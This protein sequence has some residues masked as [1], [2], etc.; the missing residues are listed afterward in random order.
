[1]L[2]STIIISTARP[3]DRPHEAGF[4]RFS[5]GPDRPPRRCRE[6]MKKTG[7]RE[8]RQD[9]EGEL[10]AARL[11][12]SSGSIGNSDLLKPRVESL[13]NGS[14]ITPDGTRDWPLCGMGPMAWM[15][16]PTRPN[17]SKARSCP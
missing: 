1:L 16:R 7:H 8:E 3:S 4:R 14:L 12:C 5:M 2:S 15:I 9:R 11:R 6:R 13:V 10:G 17:P